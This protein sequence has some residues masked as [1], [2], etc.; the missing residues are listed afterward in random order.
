[1]DIASLA[2]IALRCTAV[3]LFLVVALRIFG[4]KELT[5]LNPFDI[6]LILLISNA[7]QNAMVG[8]DVSLAGGLCA[9]AALFTVNFLIKKFLR[10][11]PWISGLLDEKPHILVHDGKADFNMLARLDIS[12]DELMETLREHGL[13]KLTDVRLALLEPDGKI[14]ILSGEHT[15]RQTQHPR[16]RPTAVSETAT[17]NGRT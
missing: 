5:Q 8:P 10:K 15:L 1:M 2:D 6:V 13:D 7:L 9:A 12:S 3:Y 14:S 17:G 4:K 11:S 16:K